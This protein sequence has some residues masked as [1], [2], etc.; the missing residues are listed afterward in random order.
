MTT[1]FYIAIAILL[2]AAYIFVMNWGCVI[3]SMRNKQRGIDRHHSAVPVMSFILTA[4]AW[5]IYPLPDRLWMVFVPLL[6]IANW[7]LLWLPVVLI[8]ER[9]KK[10]SKKAK[11]VIPW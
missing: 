7:N 4:L 2:F 6:D 1:T 8:R 3:V 9:R 5:F 10:M 11:V